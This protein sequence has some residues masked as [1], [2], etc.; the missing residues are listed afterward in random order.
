MC[1]FSDNEHSGAEA[2][3]AVFGGPPDSRGPTM[4]IVRPLDCMGR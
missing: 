4:P 3:E 2:K 1:I